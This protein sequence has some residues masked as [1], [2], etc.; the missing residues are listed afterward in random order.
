LTNNLIT[1]NTTLLGL[2]TSLTN[3]TNT[4]NGLVTTVGAFSPT[5]A[6]ALFVDAETPG[7]AIN[8]SNVSFTLANT[9]S[10]VGSLMLYRNGLE[11]TSG[12]DYS[13]AGAVLT[14]LAGS[15]PQVGDILAAYYRL[16]GTSSTTASFVDASVPVGV[17]NGVNLIF[18]LSSAP[19]PAASLKL[20][21]NGVLL[22]QG[23]DYT[24]SGLTITFTSTTT[25][26]QSGDSLICAYR[27]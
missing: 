10:P 22:M 6:N 23:G 5:S 19:N 15:T 8:A 9:P 18:T 1:V 20:Y 13:L 3:L 7:G 25:A 26:P 16:P 24:L 14:F 17:M 12:V 4:V 2:S 21:K 11:Q 27:H